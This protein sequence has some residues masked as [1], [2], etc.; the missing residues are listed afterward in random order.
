MK[1]IKRAFAEKMIREL[2]PTEAHFGTLYQTRAYLYDA[3]VTEK[4][5]KV[6]R[7]PVC[8]VMTLRELDWDWE[9]VKVK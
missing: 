3:R 4:G 2:S 7:V 1:T 8:E 6:F 9:E 5:F